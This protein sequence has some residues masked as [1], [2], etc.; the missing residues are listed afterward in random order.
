MNALI[1]PIVRQWVATGD[2][3]EADKPAL[4]AQYLIE[5]GAPPDCKPCSSV[6]SDIRQHFFYQFKHENPVANKLR[7]FLIV[8]GMLMLPGDPVTYVN[9]G[10]E[11]ESRKVLT[12]AMAEDILNTYP[13]YDSLIKRNP[14]YVDSEATAEHETGNEE[15]SNDEANSAKDTRIQQLE[16][17][18]KA[19]QEENSVLKAELKTTRS[20]LTVATNNLEKLKADQASTP[21][22]TATST[23]DSSEQPS[24]QPGAATPDQNA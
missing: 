17:D 21:V 9:E 24:A 10:E 1:E 19:T 12:D 6:W 15:A 11:N 7:K 4:K 20:K 14:D 23:A 8:G 3:S 2:V 22:T 18:L 16:A 13:S 5:I